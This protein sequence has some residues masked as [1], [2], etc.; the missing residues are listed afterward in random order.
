MLEPVPFAWRSVARERPDEGR[1]DAIADRLSPSAEF[2]PFLYADHRQPDLNRRLRKA[3]QGS[4]SDADISSMAR[5]PV[6]DAGYLAGPA[7]EERR[8]SRGLAVG[9][10]FNDGNVDVVVEDL[11]SAP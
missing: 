1:P 4:C 9:D 3:P 7:L 6:C 5:R 11:D 10:L 2:Q 8:V